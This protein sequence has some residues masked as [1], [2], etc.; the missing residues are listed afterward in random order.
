[1]RQVKSFMV[2]TC[3]GIRKFNPDKFKPVQNQTWNKP[4]G[5]L[6]TSPLRSKYGWI[7]WCKAENFNRYFNNRV[8]L[9]LSG[10]ILVVDSLK[11][12][13]TKFDWFEHSFS[14][15][16]KQRYPDFEKM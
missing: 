3:Y 5:G 1:M 11:D 9:L 15:N 12:L 14:A 4:R 8:T 6:W 13:T 2:L 16:W 10:R 7:D